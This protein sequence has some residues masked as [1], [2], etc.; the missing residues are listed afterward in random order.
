MYH[1]VLIIY[2]YYLS[3]KTIYKPLLTDLIFQWNFLAFTNY[4]NMLV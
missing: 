2:N 3:F 4:K 1:G